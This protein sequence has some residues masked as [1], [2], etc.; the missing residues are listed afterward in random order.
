[1][2]LDKGDR[3]L[4]L[5]LAEVHGAGFVQCVS[6][7]EDQANENLIP[8]TQLALSNGTS[9]VVLIEAPKNNYAR[10]VKH[11]TIYNGDSVAHDA[12]VY[13]VDGS[14]PYAILSKTMEPGDTWEYTK[15]HGW[16]QLDGSVTP[17]GTT[18]GE[19]N[20]ISDADQ[21]EAPGNA[22]IE[23]NDILNDL[24]GVWDGT[25]FT[26][27]ITGPVK[28]QVKLQAS[29]AMLT[30]LG[31]ALLVNGLSG[32]NNAYDDV[33][34]LASHTFIIAETLNLNITDEVEVESITSTSAGNVTFSGVGGFTCK[35]AAQW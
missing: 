26:S 4:S 14:T 6:H 28:F 15:A 23:F 19:F 7:F 11:I 12:T 18:H 20:A 9:A 31:A 25:T 27:P 29:A 2:L 24:S 16:H 33:A 10:R 8:E 5:D 35:I 13:Y 17:P 34:T 22:I 21:V 3:Y 30:R 32:D 1:M